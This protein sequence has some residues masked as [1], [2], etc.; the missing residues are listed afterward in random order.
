M[1]HTIIFDIGNVL[2][3]FR[4]KELYADLGFTG[5]KFEKIADATVR[6]HWWNEFDRGLMTTEEVIGHFVENAPEYREEI[7]EIYRH[8]GEIVRIYDHAI[9]WIQELK[10]SG[11]QVYVLSNWP[12]PAYDANLHTNL[13]FLE[14]VDGGVMSFQEGLIKPDR[15]IFELICKRY[16]IDPKEAVF[17]DDNAENI[18]AAKAFGLNAIRFQDYEQAKAELKKYLEEK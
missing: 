11:Y 16:D 13:R 7:T 12:R 10:Q 5:E 2:V 14:Y 18:E 8:M 17:L 3:H 9:P 4:W 15:R 1:I 6:S